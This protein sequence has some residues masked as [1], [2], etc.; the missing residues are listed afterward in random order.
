MATFLTKGIISDISRQI[1]KSKKRIVLTH[2]AFDLF[3]I[4]HSE[5]LK[6]SKKLGDY[7]VVGLDSDKRI[8]K[9]KGGDRPI[10]PLGQRVEILLEN[11]AVD[12]VFSIDDSMD[13]SNNYFINLYQKLN[14]NYVTYG[15]LFG[16]QKELAEREKILKE[17]RF[18]RISH[19]FDGLQ[20]TTKIINGILTSKKLYN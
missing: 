12:F 2:G 17:I 14:V 15:R 4:G 13:F 19:Q 20:S 16:F 10:I 7:L 5:L 6:S 3:H 9:Y 11:N 8:K 18:K 1:R